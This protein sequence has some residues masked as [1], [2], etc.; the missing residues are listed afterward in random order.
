MTNPLSFLVVMN[1]IFITKMVG[2]RI[3]SLIENG[4]KVFV[5]ITFGYKEE[6]YYDWS[7]EAS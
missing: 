3:V 7:G 2:D 5:G 1:A 4:K 6:D